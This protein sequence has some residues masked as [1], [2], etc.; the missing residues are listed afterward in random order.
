MLIAVALLTLA[1]GSII[2]GTYQAPSGAFFIAIVVIVLTLVLGLFDWTYYDDTIRIV[3]V[4]L[5]WIY[6]AGVAGLFLMGELVL[7]FAALVVLSIVMEAGQP[8]VSSVL[9]WWD[10]PERRFEQQMDTAC[11][12]AFGHYEFRPSDG[13]CHRFDD[14]EDRPKIIVPPDPDHS[15]RAA[16]GALENIQR[17]KEQATH[18]SGRVSWVWWIGVPA[19]GLWGLKKL[20]APSSRQ[21]ATDPDVERRIADQ[22]ARWRRPGFKDP[23]RKEIERRMRDCMS[24]RTAKF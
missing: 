18:P 11:Y 7:G 4:I 24:G 13:Y 3:L 14:D 21:P 22:M 8:I 20:F 5:G 19:I 12:S 9:S 23:R 17:L 16:R 10:T 2:Q 6:L 15:E 1:A